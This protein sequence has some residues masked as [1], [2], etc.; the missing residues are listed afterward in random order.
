MKALLDHYTKILT[1]NLESGK[2][3]A[4]RIPEEE[5]AIMPKTNNIYEYW[6]WFVNES[7]LLHPN[8]LKE[9]AEFTK[10]PPAEGF[11]LYDRKDGKGWQT[12]LMEITPSDKGVILT[13]RNVTNIYSTEVI[14]IKSKDHMTGLLN[15]FAY[16]RD[17]AIYKEGAVGVVFCDINGL[18]YLNDTVG[19][20]E[21]DKLIMDF[22][23]LL[24]AHFAD[25]KIY[26]ISG[27]EFV[28][29][30]FNPILK[31]FLQRAV[32][33]HKYLWVNQKVPMASIGYS[34]DTS[35][36][37]SVIEYAENMMSDDKKIFYIKYPMYH[38][39]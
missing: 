18:K 26:H 1:V 27:D 23:S 29:L 11:Y 25:Y 19:H 13:T 32:A 30:A 31:D 16:E 24:K 15:K 10:H 38:R 8:N 33:F 2:F 22:A 34:V 35:D 4:K 36:I 12:T 14:K 6:D 20:E 39:K 3:K 5:K 17:I 28:V 7:G 21:G 37:R 9:F